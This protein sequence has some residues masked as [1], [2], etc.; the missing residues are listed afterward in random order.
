[1]LGTHQSFFMIWKIIFNQNIKIVQKY[2]EIDGILGFKNGD[3][4]VV[5][6]KVLVPANPD[7]PKPLP[8]FGDI[9]VFLADKISNES[10]FSQADADRGEN[11]LKEG[12]VRNISANSLTISQNQNLDLTF[13][14]SSSARVVDSDMNPI[15]AG[16]IKKGHYIKVF[17]NPSGNAS[18]IR[19]M[20]LPL[21]APS[22]LPPS[23]SPSAT[24]SPKPSQENI[25]FPSANLKFGDRGNNVS[26]LQKILAKDSS[27]YPSG[28]VTGYYGVLTRSAVGKFQIFYGVVSSSSQPGFGM[29][30]P[31]TRQMLQ[32]VFG[33][34]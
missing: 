16:D 3:E 30:G 20:S 2:P 1:S 18:T 23:A 26:N 13:S 10:T 29:A 14:I 21:L 6:G 34:Y 22:S 28:L 11:R 17:E 15:G 4:V 33:G 19:D 7:P 8:E 25:Q 24:A 9:G 32:Q 27:L 5:S 12:A 31:K